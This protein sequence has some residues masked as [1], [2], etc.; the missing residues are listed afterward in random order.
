ML[1]ELLVKL[2]LQDIGTAVVELVD[3]DSE[4][5]INQLCVVQ[6]L[7]SKPQMEINLVHFFMELQLYLLP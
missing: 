5:K 1:F 6:T 2:P 7:Y 3:V 4:I